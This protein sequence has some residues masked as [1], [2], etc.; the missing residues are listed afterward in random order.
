MIGTISVAM[1][2]AGAAAPADGVEALRVSATAAYRAKRYAEACEEFAQAAKLAPGD[3]RLAG[4]LGLCWH[5]LGRKK[6]AVAETLRAVRLA[7]PWAE[8]DD[9]SLRRSAYFNLGLMGVALPVPAAGTCGPIP[10]APGCDRPLHACTY[11]WSQ[12]GSGGGEVGD[13]LAIARSADVARVEEDPGDEV[14]SEVLMK[15]VEPLE[16]DPDEAAWPVERGM[17]YLSTEMEVLVAHCVALARDAPCIEDLSAPSARA[18]AC[19]R[20]KGCSTDPPS[21]PDPMWEDC[22]METCSAEVKKTVK[23]AVDECMRLAASTWQV[24]CDLVAADACTGV[25][26]TACVEVG[27]KPST[28]VVHE[29]LLEPASE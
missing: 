4:D 18:I 29:V 27:A 10:P 15:V 12:M 19:L 22:S 14:S 28:R 6:E 11:G 20:K 21:C 16:R 5:R 26:A 9:A 24:R 7:G 25:V 3:A 8:H 1:L 13:V 17:V 2:L 23:S